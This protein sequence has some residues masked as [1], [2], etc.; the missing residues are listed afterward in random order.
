MDLA[1]KIVIAA[2]TCFLAVG[3]ANALTINPLPRVDLVDGVGTIWAENNDEYWRADIFRVEIVNDQE[4][5]IPAPE[6]FVSPRLFK[7][8]KGVRIATK[9]RPD[10]S[11]ELFYRLVLTQQMRRE[12][13]TGIKPR[14]SISV[15]VVQA[16]RFQKVDFVCE[17]GRLKNTGNVHIKGMA[18]G[19]IYYILPGTTRSLPAGAQNAGDGSILCPS[20]TAVGVQQRKAMLNEKQY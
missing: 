4:E 11:K 20:A 8:P 5:L 1:H 14:I 10:D 3:Q 7:A 9:N 6:V 18:N 12:E 17:E 15:P 2:A 13:A 19:K 16:P